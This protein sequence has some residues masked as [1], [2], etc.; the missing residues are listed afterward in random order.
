MTAEN[1]VTVTALHGVP[2]NV[3]RVGQG[4][5]YGLDDCRTHE[6]ATPLVEFYDARFAGEAFGPR[7]QFVS[8]YYIGPVID[9]LRR[10][11][12]ICLDGGEP[13]WQIDD[14]A[15]CRAIKLL[16]GVPSGAAI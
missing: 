4:D 6:E 9:S 7:G 13:D 3:R 15:L 8:R 5:R 10:G 12:G 2:F 11:H 14:A 16:V 1:I